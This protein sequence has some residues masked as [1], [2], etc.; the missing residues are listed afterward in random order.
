MANQEEKLVDKKKLN[1]F[2]SWTKKRFFFLSALKILD[3]EN[4]LKKTLLCVDSIF[5]DLKPVEG[6]GVN[7]LSNQNMDK[8]RLIVRK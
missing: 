2:L 5:V 4:T 8:G 6:G 3:Q 7:Y 1:G